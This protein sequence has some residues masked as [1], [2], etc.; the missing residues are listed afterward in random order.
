MRRMLLLLAGF[1]AACD[2]P[3]TCVDLPVPAIS[4]LVRDSS[5]GAPTA[6]GARLVARDGSYVDSVSIAPG[7]PELD[8]MTLTA[9]YNRP[10]V[11]DVTVRKTGYWDWV[12]SGVKV[13]K[14]RCNVN[15]VRLTARLQQLIS[16]ASRL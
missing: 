7:H 5:S 9:A 14:G 15:T 3:T 16:A 10:G 11:Y 13:S 8:S 2:S 1:A 12:R 4:V 6:S